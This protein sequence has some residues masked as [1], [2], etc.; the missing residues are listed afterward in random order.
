MRPIWKGPFVQEQ[1]YEAIVRRGER[2]VRTT[3]RAS[4]VLPAMV[5]ACVHV[6]NGRDYMPLTLTEAMV[7]QRLGHFV[8]TTKPFTFRATNA[9]KKNK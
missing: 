6:H 3:S 5:G 1:L 2:N 9:H 4:M 7:G 8:R